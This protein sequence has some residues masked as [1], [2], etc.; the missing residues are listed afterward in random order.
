[1]VA[2]FDVFKHEPDGSLRWC[3]AFPDLEAAKD[4]VRELLVSSPGKYLI[5]SQSTGEKLPAALPL[6]GPTSE[7]KITGKEIKKGEKSSMGGLT[8]VIARSFLGKQFLK[9]RYQ[10]GQTA[11]SDYSVNANR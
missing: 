10:F 8:Q 1:M 2:P 6:S 3:G 7:A 5:L 11:L 9:G 4:E